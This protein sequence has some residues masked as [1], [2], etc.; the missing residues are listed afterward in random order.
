SQKA[1]AQDGY[2]LIWHFV[3]ESVYG[4]KSLDPNT[5]VAQREESNDAE[6][7]VTD[8]KLNLVNHFPD[9]SFGHIVYPQYFYNAINA[10]SDIFRQFEDW[11]NRYKDYPNF[12]AVDYF[13]IGSSNGAQGVLTTISSKIVSFLQ[14]ATNEALDCSSS[15][16]GRNPYN[17]NNEYQQWRFEDR[18]NGYVSLLQVATGEALDCSSNGAGRNPYNPDNLY[19]Q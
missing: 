16:A 2:N 13:E 5:W 10:Y 18:G 6:S 15:G 7:K 17:S 3:R 14:I 9:F 11:K 12:I 1:N 19:Q 4:N 8:R